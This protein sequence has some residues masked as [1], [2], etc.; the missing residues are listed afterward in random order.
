MS[1]PEPG[2]SAQLY[3]LTSQLLALPSL[4]KISDVFSL[5]FN[6]LI[7]RVEKIFSVSQGNCNV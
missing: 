3:A 4:W 6:F 7:H 1:H 2:N 5:C